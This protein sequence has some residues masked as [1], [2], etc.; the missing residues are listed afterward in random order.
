MARVI[1]LVLSIVAAVFGQTTTTTQPTLSTSIVPTGFAVFGEFN[2]LGLTS[3]WSGGM[4]AIY[5][6]STQAGVYMTTTG[7]F[8]PKKAI[9]P[10]T[11]KSF[12]AISGSMRQG[13]HKSMVTTGNFV[14][15]LGGDVGPTFSNPSGTANTVSVSFSSSFI[16]TAYYK[17][18]P[19]FGAVVPVRM[20]YV[21]GIGWNPIVEAGITINLKNLPK[22]K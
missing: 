14:F 18:S 19:I 20:L 12:Y 3:K 7:D 16:A 1:V 17:V 10:T 9:D 22:G 21:T 15:L 4:S 13:V 6:V 2:Q 11:G 8:L 5:P